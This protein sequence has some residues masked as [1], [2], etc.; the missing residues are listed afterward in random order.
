M[1]ILVNNAGRI[2]GS[3]EPGDSFF[4]VPRHKYNFQMA[5]ITVKDSSSIVFETIRSVTLPDITFDTQILNQY[6]NKRVTQTKINYGTCSVIF[7]DTNDNAFMNK[8]FTPYIR[9]Y[10]HAGQGIDALG[11]SDNSTQVNETI[12]PSFQSRQGYTPTS[13]ENRYFLPEI[14]VYQ[15]HPG[16]NGRQTRMFNNIIT[17][18]S[19]DVL[20][21]SDSSPCQFTVTFQPER[22]EMFNKQ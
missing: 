14:L 2:Y 18:V 20:D 10:Y 15:F 8:I 3:M 13:T 17:N 12:V 1:S 6:N 11:T 7:I 19:V 4:R 21:Y 22:V 9:N 16:E 5:I